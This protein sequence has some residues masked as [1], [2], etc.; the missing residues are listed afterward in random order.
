MR[1]LLPLLAMLVAG[2]ATPRDA[3]ISA[4]VVRPGETWTY[5]QVNAYS[6]QPLG[7]IRYEI[8][9]AEPASGRLFRDGELYGESAGSSR[10]RY[11]LHGS[12]DYAY[13]RDFLPPFAAFPFPVSSGKGWTH[14]WQAHHPATG[15]PLSIKSYSRAGDWEQVSV[16]AGQFEALKIVRHLYVDEGE[17]WKSPTHVVQIDWYAPEANGVVQRVH[18]SEYFDYR[19]ERDMH[20]KGDRIRWELLAHR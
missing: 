9:G 3:S 11:W 15:D 6:G 18:D 12:A 19:R 2:C 1:L 5:R 16:P 14:H 17:W 13:F 20:I 8:V 4:P 7:T 10:E